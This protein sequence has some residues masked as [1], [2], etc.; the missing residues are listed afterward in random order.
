MACNSARLLF[1]FPSGLRS[2]PLSSGLHNCSKKAEVSAFWSSIG[3]VRPEI[4]DNP[5]GII[6]GE[7]PDNFSLLSFDDLRVYLEAHMS[8]DIVKVGPC[9]M[10]GE[11]MSTSLMTAMA[12]QSLE[13]IDGHFGLVSGL[14]VVDDEFRC[15]GV[16]AKSDRAKASFGLETKVGEVMSSPAITLSPNKTVKDA[17]ALMLKKKIHRIP[18]VNERSRV[19]GIVTRTDILQA[20]EALEEA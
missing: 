15:V 18:I 10:L 14:P 4:D 20:L 16:I 13:E 11:V 19:I 2:R 5:E 9:M 17:A 6:S 8:D 7:W 3:S 12:D 1:T